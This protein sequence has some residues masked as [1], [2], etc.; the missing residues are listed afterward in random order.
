MRFHGI[1]LMPGERYEAYTRQRAH[2]I[3]LHWNLRQDPN[4]HAHVFFNVS[5]FLL[6]T[7][8]I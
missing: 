2:D 3:F 1:W 6:N 5:S 7:L 8:Q 4:N